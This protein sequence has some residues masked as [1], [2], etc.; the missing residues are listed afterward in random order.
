[1]TQQTLGQISP[2]YHHGRAEATGSYEACPQG[3]TDCKA[4]HLDRQ[5]NPKEKTKPKTGRDKT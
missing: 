2:E 1:M 3:V 4:C 5:C